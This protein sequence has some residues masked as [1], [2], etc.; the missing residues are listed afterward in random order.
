MADSGTA[1]LASQAPASPWQ[2]AWRRLK[3]NRAALCALAF[4]GLLVVVAMAAPLLAPYSYEAQFRGAEQAAPMERKTSRRPG[5]EEA[6]ERLFV[7]GTDI[8]ARDNLS[9]IIYGARVSLLVG[10]LATLISLAIGVLVGLLAGYYG[11]WIDA[12]LM[13]FT[14]TVFA[15]PSV[16]LAVA[17]TAAIDEPGLWV[18]FLALGLVGWTSIA[19]VVR[20]QAISIKTL[21]YVLA[22]RA[23]GTGNTGILLRH[24]LPNCL[25]PIIVVATLTV[26]GN[27][28]GEAGLSFL[29]LGVQEPYPSWGGMLAN[30]QSQYVNAWWLAVFPGLA[31]VITVLAFNLFGD[32]L[33][34]ALDPRARK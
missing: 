25:G 5:D 24:I 14:D 19:R 3:K 12:C 4:N 20:S 23:L 27:I 16:L 29:G 11:G 21:D 2:M 1:P 7:L 9:R 26:G 33:R 30:A 31:I 15:F 18:V 34:D 8:N 32:G 10:V 13:R 28:L 22:A 17:I 6:R